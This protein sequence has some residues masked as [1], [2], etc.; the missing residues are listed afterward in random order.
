ML[1]VEGGDDVLTKSRVGSRFSQALIA[2]LPPN[3]SRA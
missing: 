3:W 2:N 1:G